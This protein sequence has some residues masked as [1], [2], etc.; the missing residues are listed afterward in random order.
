MSLTFYNPK[1]NIFLE[2]N[3][4]FWHKMPTHWSSEVD[5]AILEQ[6]KVEVELQLVAS[7]FE[8]AETK[9]AKLLPETVH[10]IMAI[11]NG[12]IVWKHDCVVDIFS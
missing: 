2:K 1:F 9:Q 3:I 12:K 5:K 6:V 11:R 4:Y 8:K 10:Y 7:T